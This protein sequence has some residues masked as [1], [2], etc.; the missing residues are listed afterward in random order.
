MK[1]A[2]ATL[3]LYCDFV[4][5]VLPDFPSDPLQQGSAVRIEMVRIE[6]GC[7]YWYPRAE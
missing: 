4:E 2:A 3:P 1:A 6:L 7:C 5:F